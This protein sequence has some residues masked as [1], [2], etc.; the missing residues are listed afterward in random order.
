M[1]ERVYRVVYEQEERHWW[2]RGRRAVIAALLERAGRPTP[3]RIL[4]AGCGT[5]R[6]LELYAA[7]GR[8]EGVDPSRQAV[9]FCR[10]RGLDGVRQGDAQRL[11]FE[12]GSFGLVAATDVIEHVPDD[13]LALREM[14]R[15]AAPGAALLLT[16][17]A[18]AWLWSAEDERLGHYRRYTLPRLRRACVDA[19]WEPA[20][21]SYFNLVLLPPI[22][23]ARRLGARAG[24][25]RRVELERTPD[26]LNGPLS[27]PMR[28]EAA[29]IR[30]GA[31][32]PAGV[33][34]AL[35]CRRG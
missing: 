6:N 34:V 9:E 5:G 11:P 13:R 33:S 22:A 35:L 15:V 10:R 21:G 23:L 18:Y 28:A 8:A 32:L 17:P 12:A 2:F 14:H 31:R 30:R 7:L 26:V 1:E 3:A 4:D 29:L 20:F 19:G 25:R 27:A 16:V 24:H